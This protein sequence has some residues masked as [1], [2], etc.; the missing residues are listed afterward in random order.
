M[1]EERAYCHVVIA[2]VELPYG[3]MADL[4]YDFFTPKTWGHTNYLSQWE[5]LCL[6]ARYSPESCNLRQ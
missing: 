2:A 4:T 3:R 6:R 5:V 1:H